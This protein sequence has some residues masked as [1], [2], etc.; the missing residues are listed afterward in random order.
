MELSAYRPLP[1]TSR[2][3]VRQ[4]L[5]LFVPILVSFVMLYLLV[6]VFDRLDILLRHDATIGASARYFLF[7]I[8]LM[9]TQITP[10]AVITAVLLCFGLLARHNEVNAF[11]ASGISLFQT[12][13][14]V[15]LTAAGISCAVLLWNETI[16]PYCSQQFQLINNLEIRKRELRG[17]L[18]DRQIWYHGGAGFYHIEHVNKAEQAIYGLVIYRLDEAF[19]L[20]SVV[21]VSKAEWRDHQW[22][23]TQPIERDLDGDRPV[24]RTLEPADI[25]I[26]ETL[27]DFLAVQREPAE[28]SFFVLRE[29]IRDLTKKGIDASEYLVD[30]HLKLAVP[31]ASMVLALVGAPIGGRVRRHPSLA[32][33]VGTGLVVGFGYWVVFGLASSFGRNGVLPPLVAAWAANVIFVLLGTAL[34]LYS[35]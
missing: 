13:A 29:W 22:R 27:D 14:P 31:F 35:D 1:V 15:I 6:D 28:L 17:V 18:S 3:L 34:F 2:Y 9:V 8:P 7:K 33:I 12:A 32:T 23:L 25:A 30:L 24:V 10:P 21:E 26:P 4:F 20:H 19:M 11:R 5:S 16:V